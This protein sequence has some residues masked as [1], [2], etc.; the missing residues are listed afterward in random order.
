MHSPLTH[1]APKN[2]DMA[3]IICLFNLHSSERT[4]LPPP[5]SL[6]TNGAQEGH[7]CPLPLPISQVASGRTLCALEPPQPLWPIN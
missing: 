5:T 7:N 2:K 3:S 4:Q 1:I 6:Y